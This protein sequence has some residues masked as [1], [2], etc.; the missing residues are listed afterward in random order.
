MESVAPRACRQM[1]HGPY[2]SFIMHDLSTCFIWGE[3]PPARIRNGGR[4]IKR[5]IGVPGVQVKKNRNAFPRHRGSWTSTNSKMN[6]DA[7]NI[8]IFKDWS[9]N[10]F[11]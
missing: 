4:R 1:P 9:P 2:S 8:S 6:R 3:L 11:L 7:L 10:K 5:M